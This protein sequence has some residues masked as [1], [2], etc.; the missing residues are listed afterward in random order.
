ML[1][2]KLL[3]YYIWRIQDFHDLEARDVIFTR[4]APDRTFTSYAD[5]EAAAR[6]YISHTRKQSIA[7]YIDKLYILPKCEDI[8]N[9]GEEYYNFKYHKETSYT[10]QCNII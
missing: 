1:I 2:N 8:R 10:N 5:A 9:A 4:V 7:P 6:I 3:M